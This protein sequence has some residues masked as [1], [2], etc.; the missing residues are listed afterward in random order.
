[1]LVKTAL[2]GLFLYGLV[3]TEPADAN[4][5][6]IGAGTRFQTHILGPGW[7]RGFI[8][9]LRTAP[10]CYIIITFKPRI[11]QDQPLRVERT[12]PI[13]RIERLQITTVPG[14]SMQEWDRLDLFTVS[15]DSWQEVDL[16]P[17]LPA[18]NECHF[19]E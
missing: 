16:D 15:E 2:A 6:P 5:P 18:K 12:I 8:N 10:P 11:S 17:L 7:H 9:Q 13:N 19:E 4:T 14:A 1:L 3:A